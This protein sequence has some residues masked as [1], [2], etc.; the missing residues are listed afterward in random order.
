[1]KRNTLPRL[2][3]SGLALLFG[4]AG[5]AD[6]QSL[7]RAEEAARR[8][9]LRAAHLEWRNAVRQAPDSAAAQAGLAATSL[10]IGDGET[11]ERAARRALQLGFDRSAGTALLM[12]AYNASGRHEELL[13]DFPTSGA[14]TEFEAG[15]LAAGRVV[16]LLALNRAA[17][18]RPALDEAR[19]LLPNAA[20]TGLAVAVL[21]VAEGDRAAA[22]A[23]VD[24]VLT[25]EP[26]NFEALLRKGT[27][28]FNRQQPQQALERFDAALVLTPGQP[29]ALLRRAELL[30]VMGQVDRAKADIDAALVVL[31][32]NAPALYLRAMMLSRTQDWAGVDALLTRLGPALANFP[33]GYL[34]QATAKRGLGQMA[35]AEDAAR[36]YLA[37]RPDDP[38]GARLVAGIE[39]EANRPADAVATLTQLAGRGAADVAAL[40]LLGRLQGSRGQPAAAVAAFTAAVALT[41]NDAALHARLAAAHLATGNIVATEAAAR[42]A[43]RIDPTSAGG[44]EMIAFV[45]LQRGDVAG[46]E[47]S[48]AQLPPATQNGEPMRLLR[49]T[50]QLMRLDLAAAETTFNGVLRDNAASALAR[51]GLARLARMRGQDD[52]ADR[53]LVEVLAREPGN[54]EA[55]QQ[56]AAAAAPG[57]PRA[58]QSRLALRRAQAAAPAQVSL[59]L[60]LSQVERAHGD[61]AGALRVLT[62]APIAGQRDLALQFA[63][64][65]AQAATGDLAA[66]E[67]AARSLLAETPGLV[68]ARRLLAG[69]LIRKG[70]SAGAEALLQQGLRDAPGDGGL[71]E[72]LIALVLEARGQ[73]A[74]LALAD[75]MARDPRAL[76]AAATLRGDLLMVAN[77]PADAAR[78]FEAAQQASPSVL[79]VARRA[80]ALRGA[81]DREGAAALLRNWLAS[82]PEDDLAGL[83]LSQL[84]IEAGRL[85]EAE[86][87]LE[88]LLTRRPSDA[89]TLNNLAWLLGEREP[90]QP[91]ARALAERAYFLDP[92]PDA[93]DTLGWILARGGEPARAV[94]LLRQ[95]AV[96]RGTASPDPQAAYKLAFALNAAGQPAAALAV[97]EPALVN[98]AA[99]PGQ[100]EAQRLLTTLRGRR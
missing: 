36:R 19:R 72:A 61:A 7:Q 96:P 87:R 53:L 6:A 26:R 32:N 97:L 95:A 52:D 79:L 59:A 70:D 55:A 74:A 45:A 25:R 20:E 3:L 28:L 90:A 40:D 71:Q 14:A 17:E 100:A 69:L 83:M 75:R 50:A 80:N 22:E 92:T 63:R 11:G 10:D 47:R 12:R 56:L 99:F 73:E 16:A 2:T 38:R 91:R 77:R 39:L 94:P 42:E 33:D 76:P 9:D 46:M 54:A 98:P 81:G 8:G 43:L 64:A 60:L 44:H 18:A 27:L 4:L 66:A 35:Q 15:Q 93:A 48:I 23:A 84:D 57:R 34:L 41:P 67:A 31:P 82:Q 21:A 65:E 89:T 78:A 5:T 68:P 51:L 24:A 37:R 49:G 62:A 85:P 30:L 29:S 13:R 58:E 1:M 88:A 86:R